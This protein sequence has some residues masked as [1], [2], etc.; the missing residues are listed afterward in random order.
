M[1]HIVWRQCHVLVVI[2]NLALDLSNITSYHGWCI[3]ENEDSMNPNTLKYL[4]SIGKERL[5]KKVHGEHCQAAAC[6]P[7]LTSMI[8][9]HKSA[10]LLHRIFQEVDKA[11]KAPNLNPLGETCHLLFQWKLGDSRV[12]SST[13]TLMERGLGGLPVL[14]NTCYMLK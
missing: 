3:R 8:T 11:S 10:G 6:Q 1:V 7:T 4:S 2:R 12:I 5:R 13:R 14:S 9:H